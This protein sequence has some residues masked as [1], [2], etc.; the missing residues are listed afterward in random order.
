VY[1]DLADAL[2]RGADLLQDA[3]AREPLLVEARATVERLKAAELRNYL[4]DD[5]VVQLEARTARLDDL[6]AATAVIYPIVLPDRLELLVRLPQGLERFTLPVPAEQVEAAARK[7]RVALQD[8]GSSAYR[9]DARLLY[10]WLVRP[11]AER[12]AAQQVQTLVFVPDGALRAI[13]MAA[14]H[15]GEQFLAQRFALAA[16]PGLTLLDPRPLDVANAK[17]LLAGVSEGVQQFAPLASV[18][19]ELAG[20]QALFGGEILLDSSFSSARLQSE[21]AS[22]RPTLVHLASHAVFTG[23]PSTSFL[24]TH[25]G[26]LTMDSLG[27][28]L[29]RT[30]LR[31]DPIELL[32]LSA[33]DTAVG[34]E[35]AG[36]GLAGVAVS[37]G[38]RSA[39]G[40][41]WPISDEATYRLII[42]FYTELRQPGVSRAL[43]LQ[44][45]QRKLIA[46]ESF[47]H[48]FFWSAF[49]LVSNWL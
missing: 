26:R 38:A 11:Y 34:D 35:R 10:D 5:C 39:L 36:L 48:P 29:G 6:T 30:R 47:S 3:Q 41:L 27:E 13:P 15:D 45:A 7:L 19:K 9:S 40:S 22:A 32:V 37:S 14:L 18:P 43:A 4:R 28:L 16:A 12:L 23:D 49:L 46:D 44:R 31:E 21:V 25:D 33:C 24:L 1:L 2:L 8:R 20:I 42:D 17:V